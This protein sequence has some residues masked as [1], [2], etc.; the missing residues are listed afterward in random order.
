MWKWLSYWYFIWSCEITC[1]KQ[2]KKCIKISF[3]HEAEAERHGQILLDIINCKT[4][5]ICTNTTDKRGAKQMYTASTLQGSGQVLWTCMGNSPGI[6]LQQNC[7]WEQMWWLCWWFLQEGI[8]ELGEALEQ[9][10]TEWQQVD[11]GAFISPQELDSQLDKV[12]V[13]SPT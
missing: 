4:L 1:T 8:Q 13:R 6:Q 2:Y 5:G 3:D 12:K 11:C 10:E 7:P 9:L